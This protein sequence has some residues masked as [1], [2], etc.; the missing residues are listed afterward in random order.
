[1]PLN[2]VKNDPQETNLE[3]IFKLTKPAFICIGKT[4]EKVLHI[5]QVI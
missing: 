1:M 2:Q 4:R 3:K 5:S